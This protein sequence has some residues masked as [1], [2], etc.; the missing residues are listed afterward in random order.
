MHPILMVEEQRN[1]ML[2]LSDK[3]LMLE[4]PFSQDVTSFT[5]YTVQK[6]TQVEEG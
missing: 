2:V 3:S 4:E 5:I 6:K 1:V